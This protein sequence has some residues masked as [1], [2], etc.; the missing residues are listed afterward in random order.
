MEE[1]LKATGDYSQAQ[2]FCKYVGVKLAGETTDGEG[3]CYHGI[4]HGTV[5]GSDP[6]AWGDPQKMM[7]PAMDMCLKVAGNDHSQYGKL[8]RCV[9]G[10]YNSLEILSADSKYRLTQIQKNPFFICS[11]QPK[12][13]VRTLQDLHRSWWP[14]PSRRFCV[15]PCE[16]WPP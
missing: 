13:Y 15:R 14:I 8:Y 12:E 10:A 6:S 11:S 9:S 16:T 7:Q 2:D 1:L 5:D 4:G 3:A